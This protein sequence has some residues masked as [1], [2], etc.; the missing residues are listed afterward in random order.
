MIELSTPTATTFYS[1]Q[2]LVEIYAEDLED[3]KIRALLD[4][5]I[6]APAE[7]T[8]ERILRYSKSV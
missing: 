2:D 7:E 1:L 6:Q 5:L 8:I 3:R 4:E